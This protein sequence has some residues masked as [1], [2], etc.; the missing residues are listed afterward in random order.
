MPQIHIQLS[1]QSDPSTLWPLF[2][3]S[4][5]TNRYSGLF[6]RVV[7]N[8]GKGLGG[9]MRESGKTLRGI[10]STKYL[11]SEDQKSKTWQL[12]LTNGQWSPFVMLGD[13]GRDLMGLR[14]R[15]SADEI[16]PLNQAIKVWMRGRVNSDWTVQLDFGSTDKLKEQLKVLGDEIGDDH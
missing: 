8:N 7:D 1:G 14:F 10:M 16:R 11:K 9:V 15:V 6:F 5:I 12:K 13:S 2:G 3:W 4:D